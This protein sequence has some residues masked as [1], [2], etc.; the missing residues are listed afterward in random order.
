M[1]AHHHYKLVL[2]KGNPTRLYDLQADPTESRN[3]AAAHPDIVSQLAHLL[4]ETCGPDACPT[5][6]KK[7]LP[8]PC[9]IVPPPS[10]SV[11]GCSSPQSRIKEA[12]LQCEKQDSHS[13]A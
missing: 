13:G 12:L 5:L 9:F 10:A 7:G 3:I 11:R 1:V 6:L 2:E 8:S 4:E